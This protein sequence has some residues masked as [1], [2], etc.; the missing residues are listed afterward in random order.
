MRGAAPEI[1]RPFQRASTLRRTLWHLLRDDSIPWAS[2]QTT[3]P[4][5][6]PR[7]EVRWIALFRRPSSNF[8]R[9]VQSRNRS[10]ERSRA[11]VVRV[12]LHERALPARV[13]KNGVPK[14]TELPSSH[15]LSSYGSVG[16]LLETHILR[17]EYGS[18]KIATTS[19][20][21]I[22][23]S[24]LSFDRPEGPFRPTQ[25]L[26]LSSKKGSSANRPPVGF[27]SL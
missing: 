8:R 2:S 20:E 4:T 17:R 22:V 27:P 9:P 13:K 21:L 12:Q 18:F 7:S 25:K 14:N 23:H 5:L 26:A 11:R 16:Q 6:A 19:A 3:V 1:G 10:E 24:S 15:R